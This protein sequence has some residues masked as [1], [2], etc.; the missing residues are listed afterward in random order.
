VIIDSAL[1]VI[2]FLRISGIGDRIPEWMITMIRNL[3]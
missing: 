1:M 2:I 3:L